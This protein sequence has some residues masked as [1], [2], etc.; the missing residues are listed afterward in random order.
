MAFGQYYQEFRKLA[1]MA[2]TVHP[3]CV[4]ELKVSF[5]NSRYSPKITK[6]GIKQTNFHCVPGKIQRCSQ[7]RKHYF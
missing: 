3:R 6:T 1:I 7:N 2:G 5:V 4:L